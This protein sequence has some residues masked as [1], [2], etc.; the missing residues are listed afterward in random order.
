[1]EIWSKSGGNW[2]SA[3]VVAYDGPSTAASSVKLVM[4]YSL[5]K[6]TARKKVL[7]GSVHLRSTADW[8]RALVEE[9][10]AT[11]ACQAKSVATGRAEAER[12]VDG[13]QEDDWDE[14]QER[15]LEPQPELSRRSSEKSGR[16]KSSRVLT[17]RGGYQDGHDQ[18]QQDRDNKA[19]ICESLTEG[20]SFGPKG[21]FQL[22]H[23]VG[24]GSFSKVHLVTNSRTG[25]EL[26][27][28]LEPTE[29]IPFPQL[30]DEA[31]RLRRLQGGDGFPQL[32]WFGSVGIHNVMV[33]EHCGPSLD[34]MLERCGG[35]LGLEA[36]FMLAAQMLERLE[37]LHANEYLHRDLK[38][39]NFCLGPR[40]TVYML[41]LGLAKRFRKTTT[42]GTK[43]H[44][45]PRSGL[46]FVGTVRYA[47]IAAQRR[48]EQ[49][50]RDDLESLGYVFLHMLTGLPWQGL[51]AETKEERQV[52]IHAMKTRH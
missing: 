8:R 22:R 52:K 25:E 49:S 27:A 10:A 12:D 33:M 14:R 51:Q 4:E 39:G 44:I 26:A 2:I 32:H 45:P 6:G 38:P 34:V 7:P 37:F 24:A 15:Q 16:E 35:A 28:K 42:S 48:E 3:T 43:Q 9:K 18:R 20:S 29:G 46:A 41:D 30:L 36:L 40:R 5:P 47:S 21:R 13:D 19:D 31:K 17:P 23:E 11:V 1:M 50:R